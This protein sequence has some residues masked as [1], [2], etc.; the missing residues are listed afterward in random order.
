[1]SQPP[2]RSDPIDITSD[3]GARPALFD[4]MAA[5]GT[6]YTKAGAKV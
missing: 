2:S 3:L 6:L 5:S 1:M 4:A